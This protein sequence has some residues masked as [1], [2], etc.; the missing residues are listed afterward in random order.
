M[1]GMGKKPIMLEYSSASMSRCCCSTGWQACE[2]E[3]VSVCVGMYACVEGTSSASLEREADG[4]P[5]GTTWE[6]ELL[7][8]PHNHNNIIGTV[9]VIAQHRV[10]IA[11]TLIPIDHHYR[12]TRPIHL[13][14]SLPSRSLSLSPSLCRSN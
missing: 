9:V 13:S 3:C 4:L 8:M 2:Y 5:R 14:S 11:S 7:C 12:A 10:A 1:N 6:D